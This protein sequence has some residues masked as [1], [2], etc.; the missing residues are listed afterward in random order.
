M[1][2]P[3]LSVAQL[4][5]HSRSLFESG[6]ASSASDWQ[7]LNDH[8][9]PAF[10]QRRFDEL[11][12]TMVGGW[13][14]SKAEKDDYDL[15]TVAQLQAALGRLYLQAVHLIGGTSLKSSSQD[16]SAGQARNVHERPLHKDEIDRLLD[17][18][19]DSANPQLKFIVQLLIHTRV[20][21]RDLLEARWDQVDLD[22]G[23]WVMPPGNGGTA[24][25]VAL[26]PAAVEIFRTLARWDD[27]PFVVA[28]PG[29]RRPY[30]SFATSWDT[31][32][33]KAGIPDVEI[34]DLRY[35]SI[36]EPPLEQ[37]NESDTSRI[38]RNFI[39]RA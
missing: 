3:L 2:T 18:A 16:G 17:A 10:G 1:I 28:N 37:S 31:A 11:T 32:R 38:V 34:D 5:Q 23:E 27:C 6:G 8:I 12:P 36:D 24:R 22:K 7:T 29:T 4:I 15:E 20:R 14:K 19:Q 35:Y 33:C 21:Q 25:C 13:L 9:V 30:R 39:N 26:S